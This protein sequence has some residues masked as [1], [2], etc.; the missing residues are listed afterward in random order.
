MYAWGEVLT[1]FKILHFRRLNIG[2]ESQCSQ[3]IQREALF[4]DDKQ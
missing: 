3:Q 1:R 2:I 4:D